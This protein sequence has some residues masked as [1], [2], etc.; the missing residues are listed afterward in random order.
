[1][2]D[3][4][5]AGLLRDLEGQDPYAVLGVPRSASPDEIKQAYRARMGELHS[6]RAVESQRAAADKLARDVNLAFEVLR[7]AN[8]REAYDALF[9]D[10]GLA[11][12]TGT[13]QNPPTSRKHQNNGTFMF[14]YPPEWD[15]G[16]TRPNNYG[17]P[18]TGPPS[19]APDDWEDEIID[20][21]PDY[22]PYR[23]SDQQ[24][25]GHLHSEYPYPEYTPD[26]PPSPSYQTIPYPPTWDGTRTPGWSGRAIAALVFSLLI[27]PVGV[28]LAIVALRDISRTGRRGASL[29]IAALILGTIFILGYL[30][31]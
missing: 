2:T 19:S 11:A 28:I 26:H 21:V 25:H 31:T 3:R 17:Q 20:E 22:S 27:P 10:P 14:D 6:D 5:L 23:S 30:I 18:G 7:D 12:P 1:M 8:R 29:A 24:K 9:A 13:G 4:L 16:H 15:Q